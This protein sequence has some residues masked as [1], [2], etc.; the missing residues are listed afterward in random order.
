MVN[1]SASSTPIGWAM[2]VGRTPYPAAIAAMQARAAAIAD[3]R[4]GELVWLLEH[5]PLYTAGVSAKDADLLNPE[6]F[7]VFRTERGGQFTYHGPGQRV[8]YVMLDLTR[9]G[10][11][12]RAFVQGL[13]AWLIEA[14][15]LLGVE[16]G[17][18]EGRVGVWVKRAGGRADKIAAI[19]VR[20]KRW[21]SYHGVALNVRPDLSHFGGIIPC[22]VSDPHFGVTS[23]WDLG[24][25]ASREEV[26]KALRDAF[27]RRFAPVVVSPAPFIPDREG[28]DAFGFDELMTAQ[29]DATQAY[30]R[31]RLAAGL[32]E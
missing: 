20:L 23:L 31:R 21:V 15:A 26:D 30:L 13:E 3:G 25:E 12:V 5:P 19:G 4:A 18:V 8:G 27:E 2:S 6:R 16:A 28:E 29:P 10:R 14:L 7:P 11:D 9:R 24:V 17:A 1:A 22:G 32:P